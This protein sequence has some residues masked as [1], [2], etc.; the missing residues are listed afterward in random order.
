MYSKFG[1][2]TLRGKPLG[3]SRRR[4]WNK[5]I[6][7]LKELYLEVVDWIHVAQNRGQ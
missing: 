2:K 7:D 6:M 3:T 1:S 5:I 4:W